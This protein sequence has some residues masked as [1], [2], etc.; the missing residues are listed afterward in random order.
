MKPA[1]AIMMFT[2]LGPRDALT[3]PR[4]S[5]RSGEIVTNRSK[6]G[7]LVVLPAAVELRQ[8]L[9]AAASHHAITCVQ[10]PWAGHGPRA[11]SMRHGR[12]YA[13]GSNN[14]ARSARVSLC[15]A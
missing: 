12:H 7:E 8:I 13:G 9:E 4:S 3:L 6:T 2:G 10:I 5:F 11:A 14:Q 15:T 1:I